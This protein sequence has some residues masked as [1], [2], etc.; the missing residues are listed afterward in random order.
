LIWAHG[1][2]GCCVDR[3]NWHDLPGLENPAKYNQ[4]VTPDEIQQLIKAN[5]DETVSIVYVDGKTEELFV[6]SV[7]DEGFVVISPTK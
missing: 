6:H 3:L 2:E 7:D 1:L 4:F 5:I